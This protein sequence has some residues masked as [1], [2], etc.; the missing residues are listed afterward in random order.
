MI[1]IRLILDG[2]GIQ[3]NTVSIFHAGHIIGQLAGVS[4][5]GGAASKI[6][7]AVYNVRIFES[8]CRRPRRTPNAGARA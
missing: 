2:N 1:A 3:I 4:Q 6:I 5:V 7:A 8:R